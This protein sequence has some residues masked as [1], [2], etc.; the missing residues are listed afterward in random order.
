MML[1]AA[2]LVYIPN[3]ARITVFWSGRLQAIP[4]LGDS[5]N[6]RD[7]R[8]LRS[9]PA[10]ADVM[11]GIFAGMLDKNGAMEDE[12]CPWLLLAMTYCPPG[13]SVFTTAMLLFTSV[14]FWLYS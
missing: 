10:C 13:T 7:V 9:Q 2:W 12:I 5:R 3:P 14:T 1:Y 6:G 4:I 8:R 11:T